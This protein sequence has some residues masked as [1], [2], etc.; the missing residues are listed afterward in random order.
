MTGP[1]W[2]YLCIVVGAVASFLSTFGQKVPGLPGNLEK[3]TVEYP[4]KGLALFQVTPAILRGV[5]SA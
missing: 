3:L 4:H 1:S 5:V 2:G